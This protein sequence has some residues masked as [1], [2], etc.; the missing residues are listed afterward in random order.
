MESEMS[1]SVCGTEVTKR[2]ILELFQHCSK[3]AFSY[4]LQMFSR[5]IPIIW[6]ARIGSMYHFGEGYLKKNNTVCPRY[7]E[8][9]R[10]TCQDVGQEMK[11]N[12]CHETEKTL[13]LKTI[14]AEP[15]VPGAFKLDHLYPDE[16]IL[17]PKVST[18]VLFRKLSFPRKEKEQVLNA[19]NGKHKIIAAK[20]QK[21]VPI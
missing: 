11:I 2:A 21:Q 1:K 16:L 20:N 6:R 3:G 9:Y 13:H 12:W 14:Y 10:A 7:Y 19:E 4:L 15:S 18:F 8:K 5:P 17:F